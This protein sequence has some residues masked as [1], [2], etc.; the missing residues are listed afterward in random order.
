MT[1]SELIHAAERL[2]ADERAELLIRLHDSLPPEHWPQPSA[3]TMSEAMRLGDSV[4]SG[5]IETE[6]WR[7]VRAKVRRANGLN[8]SG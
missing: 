4:E 7:D 1:I 6:D 8:A 3:P 2:T 5:E